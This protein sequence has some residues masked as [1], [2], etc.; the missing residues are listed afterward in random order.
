MQEMEIDYVVAGEGVNDEDQPV[1]YVLLVAA[2]RN[3]LEQLITLLNASKLQVL[4]IDSSVL[5]LCRGLA[6]IAGDKNMLF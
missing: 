2:R 5:S 1:V 6:P 3:M 4:D